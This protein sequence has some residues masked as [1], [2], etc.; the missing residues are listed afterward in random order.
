MPTTEHDWLE[1]ASGYFEKWQFPHCLGAIDGKHIVMRSP[2]NSG[3]VYFNYK[4]TFSIVLLALADAHLQFVMIDVGAYGRNSDGGIFAHSNF[5]KALNTKALCLPSGSHL[6]GAK[7]LGD[8][9]FVF[10]GDEA[11]PLHEHIMRPYPG[12]G[13]TDE[14]RVF[15]Y[16]LSRARRC[17]ESAFGVLATRWRVFYTKIGVTP[18]TTKEIVKATVVLHNLLQKETTATQTASMLHDYSVRPAGGVEDLPRIGVHGSQQAADIRDTFRNYFN[19]FNVL[20]W[21]DNSV[22]RGYLGEP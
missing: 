12:R 18:E 7:Q 3:S 20:P 17:V 8:V 2:D 6:P 10:I 14:Q 19:H 22:R 9:P 11:F 1:I 13:C 4:G 5:G 21:Q 15:N 16:R